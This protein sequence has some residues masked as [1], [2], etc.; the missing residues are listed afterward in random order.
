M[1]D[2]P[3][4]HTTEPLTPPGISIAQFRDA[5]K[6]L[7]DFIADYWQSLAA[8]G[9]PSSPTAPPTMPS[10]HHPVAFA[11]PV[12]STAAPG[13]LLRALPEAC[14]ESPE[15][16]DAIMR[17]V[18]AL[19]MPGITHWQHPSFF[20]FFPANASPAAILGEL[21]SAGLGV[22]GMLW[23]TSP[24]CTELEM[25]VL[26]WLAK[27][28]DLPRD[29]LHEPGDG[30]PSPGGSVIMGT[31]SEGTLVALVAA[32]H[33]ARAATTTS[34]PT[35][36]PRAHVVYTST[37]A[38]SSVIK[39]AMIA[40]LCAGPD[41]TPADPSII[42]PAPDGSHVRLVP[43]LPD[44]SMDA[45]ALARLINA[46]I[47][48][49]RVPIAVV[50]TV[51][52]TGTMAI[53]DV[54]AIGRVC[55]EHDV[56]LHVDAAFAGCAA[57][58]PEFR[59]MLHARD[60]GALARVDSLGF[61]PHKWLLTNFDCHCF[62]TRDR[63]ALTGALSITPEYLRNAA[64]D[65]GRVIDYRDWQ[66]PLGRRFRALKLWFVLRSVG[67]AG[68]REYIRSHVRMGEVF[69]SLVRSDARF[70]VTHPREL[71]MVCFAPRPRQGE[72]LADVNTR[73][74]ELLTQVNATG[75]AFL[76]HTVVPCSGAETGSRFVLR[77][78]IGGT[79]TREVHVRSAWQTIAAALS[80]H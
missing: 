16:W 9:D 76:T 7:V 79:L 19:I 10:P 60:P 43:T 29:M 11:M 71:S 1:P 59:W 55:Q 49:G 63:A 53:D 61:N 57:V 26:D 67:A 42:A 46:D 68:L 74:R 77:L 36:S 34:N 48:A 64:S 24:A 31:A 4:A 18:P 62:Y 2:H 12:C 47:L 3:P 50:A 14:P 21:L 41:A 15:P 5:G 65:A 39:A 27:L 78:A 40:G 75:S 17:D 44:L 13:D 35:S 45:A 33:R 37:Q 25:R 58:C 30:R 69:E 8:V 56:W 80:K 73:A 32:R 22:Q 72:L 51:G 52:T 23:S 28:I 70:E 38:H 66:V 54:D 20:G 6:Q